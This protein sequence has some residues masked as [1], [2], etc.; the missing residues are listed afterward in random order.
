[1][2][3]EFDVVNHNLQLH[4]K[5]CVEAWD[6]QTDGFTSESVPSGFQY[7]PES[8]PLFLQFMEH[9]FKKKGK[10]FYPKDKEFYLNICEEKRSRWFLTIHRKVLDGI[11]EKISEYVISEMKK[12]M[13]VAR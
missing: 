13:A 2:L 6:T 8:A 4:V 5:M 11:A 1:M 7:T 3:C 9:Q 12:E 10:K